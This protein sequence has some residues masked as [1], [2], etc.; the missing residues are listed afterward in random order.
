M[1]VIGSYTFHICSWH[2]RERLARMKSSLNLRLVKK[3]RDRRGEMKIKGGPHLTQSA[4]YPIQLGLKASKGYKGLFLSDC[5]DDQKFLI[6]MRYEWC[7]KGSFP[8][9]SPPWEIPRLDLSWASMCFLAPQKNRIG[10]IDVFTCFSWKS[11]LLKQILPTMNLEPR[12][13]H[14]PKPTPDSGLAFDDIDDDSSDSG[15]DHIL[16]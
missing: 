1:V 11:K 8:K 2:A 7:L 5:H 14:K 10:W 16:G 4:E 9:Y 13:S 3:Y 6:H 12:K 15:I